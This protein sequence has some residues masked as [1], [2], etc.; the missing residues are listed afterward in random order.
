MQ[1]KP[2][3]DSL[4]EGK[5]SLAIHSRKIL[6]GDLHLPSRTQLFWLHNTLGN[7]TTTNLISLIHFGIIC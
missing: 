2:A 5:Q 3:E 7:R 4:E 1:R 6:Y